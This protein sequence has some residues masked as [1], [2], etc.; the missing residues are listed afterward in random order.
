M[1]DIKKI[2]GIKAM[3]SILDLLAPLWL[4]TGQK[5]PVKMPVPSR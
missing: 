3:L 5:L 2:K 4:K 1:M